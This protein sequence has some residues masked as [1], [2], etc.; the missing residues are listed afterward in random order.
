MNYAKQSARNAY[1]GNA[2]ATASPARLLVML[3]DRLVLDAERGEAALAAGLHEECNSQLQHAQAIV[4]E[5]QSTLDVDRMPAGA[6][7]MAL[8]DYLQRQL[9]SA[10]IARDRAAAA[11]AVKIA[12]ELCDTWRQAALLAAVSA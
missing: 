4:T 2:V 8:Y 3:F 11:E 12:R 7:M 1:Q 6:E 10:N 9:V 5:L